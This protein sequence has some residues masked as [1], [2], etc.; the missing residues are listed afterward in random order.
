MKSNYELFNRNNNSIH[1]ESWNYRG[2][3]HQTCPLVGTHRIVYIRSIPM[4][5]LKEN[6]LVISR[7]YLVQVDS[8]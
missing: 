6:E 8:G 4:L 2:C 5:D 7:H 3:W 1:Y